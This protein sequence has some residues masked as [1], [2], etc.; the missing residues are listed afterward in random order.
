MIPSHLLQRR[1]EG[2][3]SGTQFDTGVAYDS[4]GNVTRAKCS[5]AKI[6]IHLKAYLSL[7]TGL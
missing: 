6:E 3:S 1:I 4:S 5:D 7:P 2:L